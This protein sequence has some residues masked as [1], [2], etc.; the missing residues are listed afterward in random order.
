MHVGTYRER[1]DKLGFNVELAD[2]LDISDAW[3]ALKR[4]GYIHYDY[5][6][7]RDMDVRSFS[8]LYESWRTAPAN[9]RSDDDENESDDDIA[10]REYIA[11][12]HRG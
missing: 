8:A 2:L 3:A 11:Q 4:A 5:K 10:V 12:V 1:L 7:G 6:Q 9:T